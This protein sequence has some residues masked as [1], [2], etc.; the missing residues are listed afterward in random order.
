MQFYS[1]RDLRTSPKSVWESLRAGE[2]V[3]TNN[4]KPAALMLDLTQRDFE[5]TLQAVRQARAIMAMKRM[6]E[7]AVQSGLDRMSLDE[8]NAEIA[9]ARKERADASRGD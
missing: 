8:I 2:V 3:I 4:G 1:V 5:E 9:A 6:Q 7:R